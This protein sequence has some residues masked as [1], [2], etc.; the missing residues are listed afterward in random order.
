[1]KYKNYFIGEQK[2]HTRTPTTK[3]EKLD[4]VEWM[5]AYWHNKLYRR[6]FAQYVVEINGLQWIGRKIQKHIHL[7]SFLFMPA[8]AAAAAFMG[9]N[10]SVWNYMYGK[11][12]MCQMFLSIQFLLPLDCLPS[13]NRYIYKIPGMCWYIFWCVI[14][15]P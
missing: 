4:G 3:I 1:M 2:G 10:F 13:T 7:T 11:M 6:C 15:S 9:I 8:A 5:K 14:K 12:Q